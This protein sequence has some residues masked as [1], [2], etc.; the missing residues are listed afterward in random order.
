MGILSEWLEYITAG[1]V[2]WRNMKELSWKGVGDDG[3]DT[4]GRSPSGGLPGTGFLEDGG[5]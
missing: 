4:I 2:P 1:G 3:N 5:A